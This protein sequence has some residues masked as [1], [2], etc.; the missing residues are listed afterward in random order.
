MTNA[1]IWE[2]DSFYNPRDIVI[3]GSGFAGLWSAYHLKKRNP[4]LKILVVEKGA[5][6][7]GA[8]TRNAGFACFGSATELLGDVKI[9]GEE[10]M[11]ELVAMRYEGLQL[12]NKAFRNNQIDYKRYGGYELITELQFSSRKQLKQQLDFLNHLLRQVTGKDRVF[13]LATKKISLF[14]FQ[15]MF[16]L[17]ENKLDGQLHSGKLVQCLLQKI[18]SMGVT[19][20]NN[21][22]L[23]A[24]EQAGD[25]LILYTN[26]NFPLSARK[27]LLCT[28]TFSAGLIPGSVIVP[29]R[30]QILLTAPIKNLT[31]KGSFHYDEGFYYFRNLGNR[32]LL[33]GARNKAFEEANTTKDGISETVQ[34]E[35]ERFLREVV[36]PGQSF[37]IDHRWSG[38][39]GMEPQRFPAVKKIREN[40][41]YLG[42]LGGMGVALAPVMGKEV[43]KLMAES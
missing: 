3:A 6:P 39:M 7:S 29:A 33:G 23:K 41:F 2:L 40:L 10:K 42:G 21:I 9:M 13:G 12:I 18:Q 27:L 43:A 5:V 38:I 1:S 36:I 17:I 37:K 16:Q 31:F 8:S 11:I 35:L 30:G 4:A 25:Q 14:G 28:N 20:W 26:L 34:H 19:V 15:Q 22:E 32:I 24:F